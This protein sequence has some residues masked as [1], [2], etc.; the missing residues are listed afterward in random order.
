MGTS[1]TSNAFIEDLGV[2]LML[3]LTSD[4]PNSAYTFT[5]VDV[6]R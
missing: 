2:S 3:E 5:A 4:K 1:K 6:V